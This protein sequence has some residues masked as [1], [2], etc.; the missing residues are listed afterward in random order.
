[1]R[2]EILVSSFVVA[3]LVTKPADS[4]DIVSVRNGLPDIDAARATGTVIGYGHFMEM[5]RQ[6]GP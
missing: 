6:S 4:C 5:L 3:L 2:I 1:M